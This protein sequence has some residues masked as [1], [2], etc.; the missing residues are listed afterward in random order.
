LVSISHED[1]L[2]LWDATTGK[3][4]A[5]LKTAEIGHVAAFSPDS[6]TVAT[7]MYEQGKSTTVTLWDAATGKARTTL[8]G[9]PADVRAL[10]F[11]PDGKTLACGCEDGTIKLW[12]ITGSKELVTLKG[13]AKNVLCLTF[14][15]DGKTLASGSADKTIKLWDVAKGK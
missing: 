10:V 3:K 7:T 1:E 9:Y 8:K 11:S 4:T 14:S 13:H 2:M 6:K 15:P 5:T 12:A